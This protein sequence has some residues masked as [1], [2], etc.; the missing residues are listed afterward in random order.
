MTSKN[1]QYALKNIYNMNEKIAITTLIMSG[2]GIGL[3]WL[4]PVIRGQELDGDMILPFLLTLAFMVI[5]TILATT[6]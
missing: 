6:I 4:M 5:G 1:A 3:A 2:I